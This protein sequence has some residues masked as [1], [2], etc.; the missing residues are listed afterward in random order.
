MLAPWKKSNDKPRQCI[1][2]Q[3]HYLAN[4]GPSS[5]SYGFSGSHVP[6]WE[7]CHKEG[8][9][10][11]NRCFEVWCWR[12]L[13]IVPWAPGRSNQSMLKEINPEY[14]L[15]ELLLKLEFQYLGYLMWRADSLEKT[16]MLGKT[17]GK[18]RRDD[19]GWDGWIASPVQW[20]EFEQTLGDGRQRSLACCSPWDCSQTQLTG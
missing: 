6:M 20:H 15:E 19:R 2:K 3:R 12:R 8:W 5:Q 7:L 1:K 11:K 10:L 13:F 9:L 17:E 14:S 4:K 18:R 16:L